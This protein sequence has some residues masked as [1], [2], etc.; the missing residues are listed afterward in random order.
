MLM[1]QMLKR[2]MIQTDE[3]VMAGYADDLVE[4]L[5]HLDHEFP[6]SPKQ[7]MVNVQERI[8]ITG[9]V[10]LFHDPMTFLEAIAECGLITLTVLEGGE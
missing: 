5:S 8:A 4:A 6:A 10:I 9:R 2:V 7:Y 1:S 3:M